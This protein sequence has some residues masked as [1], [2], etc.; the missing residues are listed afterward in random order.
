MS[1][2]DRQVWITGIGLLSSLG[3]GVDAHWSAVTGKNGPVIDEDSYAPYP[4]HP[5]VEVDF[6]TQIKKRGD[7]RQMEPWQRIGTYSAGLAIED[8]GLTG[9]LEM[10]D[11]MDMIVAAG[12][13]E[14]DADMDQKVL[15]STTGENANKGHSNEILKSELRPTLFLAQLSNLL[16]GNISIVHKVTGSSRTYM[17]EELAGLASIENA[18]NRISSGQSDLML[19][20]GANNAQRKDALLIFEL[21]QNLWGDKFKSVWERDG[22][23]LVMGSVGAFLVLESAAHAKARGAKAYA[24]MSAVTSGRCS[25]GEGEARKQLLSQFETMSGKI[26]KE[27]IGVMSGASGCGQANV[28]ELVFLSDLDVGGYN[29]V[30][31]T[32]GSLLG[33]S[34]EAHMPAGL[35]L[36][37]LSLS[38]GE[39][40]AP[41]EESEN[42]E[43]AEGIPSQILVTS[44]GHWRG[45]GL[46]LVTGVDS[47]EAK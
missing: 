43:I 14:R 4:V 7:L 46:A 26:D 33:H 35:A 6:A 11:T 39:Y 31:R 32:Y 28:E 22:G 1:S 42:E 45:E 10:L 18:F 5:L 44:V 12:S 30:M 19:I 2:D 40:P 15:E 8:A 38:K 29:P 3:E 41:F 13:G 47:K 9:N 16:A 17:G 24:K 20:G 25:R 37:A 36:A 23:G 34:F 21:G 27:Q